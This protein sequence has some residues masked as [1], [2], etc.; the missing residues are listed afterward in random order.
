MPYESLSADTAFLT[1][2]LGLK[3]RGGIMLDTRDLYSYREGR[4]YYYR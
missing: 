1:Q 2:R 4:G 3:M